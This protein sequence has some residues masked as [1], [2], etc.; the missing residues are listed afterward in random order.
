MLTDSQ[1]T[2]PRQRVLF[3]VGLIFAGEA[4]YALPYHVARFFRSSV[5]EVFDITATE[6]GFAQGMLGVIAIFSYVPGGLIADRYPARN[7]LAASLWM[8]ALGGL[9]MLTFPG[10]VGSLMIWSF[11]ALSSVLLFWAALIRATR[12][13]G[14]ADEQGRAYGLLDGGRGLFA[15]GLASILII[16]LG[17]V[18]PDGYDAAEDQRR[19]LGIVIFSYTAV[20]ALTGVLVW[21]VVPGIHPNNIGER[22]RTEQSMLQHVVEVV[23][24]PAVWLQALIIVCAYVAYKGFDN[25]QLFFVDAYGLDDS[26]ATAIVTLG[27]WMRPIAALAAGILADRFN[28]SR[29]L[30]L[31][32]A[33]LLASDLYFA[34]TAPSI[35]IATSWALIAN[36]LTASTAIFALRGLYFAMFEEARVPIA[37]TGTA[38]GVVS[39]V[40][41]TPDIFTALVAG[42]FI[43]AS[44]GLAGHQHFFMF[45]SVF[46][47]LGALTSLK[48]MRLLHSRKAEPR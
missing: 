41:Y 47:F 28:V 15:A 10:Y 12:D 31:S 7:L 1:R 27:S 18:F 19:A 32:F 46:A 26:D 45:L 16:V 14:G 2:S 39:L 35:G 43:D 11:F 23:R 48:L 8:T 4:V 20:T 13:W 21:F 44:P 3:M 22:T 42:L 5:L 29:M 38:V 36:T 17:L 40:G 6:L 37:L 9:Y 33:L 24:I 34:L 30:L 25:Y